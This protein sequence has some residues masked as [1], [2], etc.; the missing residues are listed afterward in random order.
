MIQ[1]TTGPI[2]FNISEKET[3][4]SEIQVGGSHYNRM[5]IQ[6]VDFIYQNNIPF[7][8]GCVIKYVCRH[9]QKNGLEDLKKAK[10]FIDLLI[11]KEYPN[12]H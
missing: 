4:P 5:K 10:H 2:R 3:L 8:E 12:E 9:R 11:E 7:I 1:S 6:P